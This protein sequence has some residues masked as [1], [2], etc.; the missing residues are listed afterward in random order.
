MYEVK[1]LW[2]Y[3]SESESDPRIVIDLSVLRAAQ[4]ESLKLARKKQLWRG[5][6]HFRVSANFNQSRDG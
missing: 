1:A 4:S 6:I 3:A 2:E 5:K